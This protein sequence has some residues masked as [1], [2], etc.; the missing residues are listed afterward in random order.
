MDLTLKQL[1]Y[2]NILLKRH[3]QL[4]C[5]I[6][7]SVPSI[8]L[9]TFTPSTIRESTKIQNARYGFTL[10]VINCICDWFSNRMKTNKLRN[11]SYWKEVEMTGKQS[12]RSMTEAIID[13]FPIQ[14]L[15]LLKIVTPMMFHKK[16][17]FAVSIPETYTGW[18]N[19][20][21][22]SRFSD[23]NV[24]MWIANTRQFLIQWETTSP[25]S[26]SP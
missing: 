1:F 3:T 7:R 24:K 20:N 26:S 2:K 15:F 11:Y 25:L 9:S 23:F 16:F 5:L 8:L 21:V 4:T 12:F 22:T 14:S 18:C 10:A 19:E 6:H 13:T 17:K